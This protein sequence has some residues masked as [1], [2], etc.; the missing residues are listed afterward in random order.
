MGQ[1]FEVCSSVT[2]KQETKMQF[3]A[4]QDR[5]FLSFIVN[6]QIWQP[7]CLVEGKKGTEIFIL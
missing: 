6:C 4:A 3:V 1:Y 5:L 7:V 2:L